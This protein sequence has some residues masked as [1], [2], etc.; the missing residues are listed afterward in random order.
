MSRLLCTLLF[1]LTTLALYC[2]S[3]SP[4]F[5]DSMQTLQWLGGLGAL[6]LIPS[7]VILKFGWYRRVIESSRSMSPAPSRLLRALTIMLF[8]VTAGSLG[9]LA[10]VDIKNGFSPRFSNLVLSLFGFIM[11]CYWKGLIS[12]R[13]R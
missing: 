4:F 10:I 2:L 7:I 3:I 9:F 11:F 6:A 13:V 12:R 5:I 8:I 1:G